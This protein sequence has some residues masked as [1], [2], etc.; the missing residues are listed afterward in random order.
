M[1]AIKTKAIVEDDIHLK[2]QN[3]IN[4]LKKG[5]LVDLVIISQKTEK[6]KQWK[7]VLSEIGTYSDEELSGFTEARK[8]FNKWQPR[9]F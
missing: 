4:S 7:K 5:T 2:L 9:E 1:N 6:E 8:E 3:K